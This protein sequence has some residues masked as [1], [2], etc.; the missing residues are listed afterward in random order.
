MIITFLM[1]LKNIGNRG[2]W[3]ESNFLNQHSS[4][5]WFC[6]WINAAADGSTGY[7]KTT[8]A[9][10]KPAVVNDAKVSNKNL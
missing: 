9:L 1:Y 7:S 8:E 2:V 5:R 10:L 4:C 3:V 6:P